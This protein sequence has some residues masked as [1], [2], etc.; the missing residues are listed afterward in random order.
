MGALKLPLHSINLHIAKL[1]PYTSVCADALFKQSMQSTRTAGNANVSL[2]FADCCYIRSRLCRA[3]R[4]T[5]NYASARAEH[6]Q[7]SLRYLCD[8][9]EYGLMSQANLYSNARR[10]GSKGAP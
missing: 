2:A 7:S 5:D 3:H 6:T 8:S 10:M 9:H 1:Y 4:E